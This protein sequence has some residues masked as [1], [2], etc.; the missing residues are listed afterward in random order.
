MHLQS[1][2]VVITLV[3][4]VLAMPQ[5]LE[6]LASLDSDDSQGC[7]PQDDLEP[8]KRAAA[9]EVRNKGFTYGPSLIGEAAFFPNGTLGNARSKADYDLW[10]VDR[11]EIDS[12]ITKDVE[13]VQAAIKGVSFCHG[14]K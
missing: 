10:A 2:C 5:P 9:V 3:L 8:K 7:I 11:K 6:A 4:S 1:A 12:R 14:M 13:A